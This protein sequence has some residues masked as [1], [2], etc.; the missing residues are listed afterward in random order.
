MTIM[1][2]VQIVI[3]WVVRPY[4]L[5]DWYRRFGGTCCF[6]FQ[7]WRLL[8]SF[9]FW[10]WMFL[11]HSDIRLQD[12]MVSVV[13]NYKVIN[14]LFFMHRHTRNILIEK[15]LREPVRIFLRLQV[16]I[17]PQAPKNFSFLFICFFSPSF[18]Q[19]YLHVCDSLFLLYSPPFTVKSWLISWIVV[20][21]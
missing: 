20:H 1:Y 5:T 15:Y 8:I 3:F 11:Q 10:R 12:Y 4:N 6:R 2:G 13:N 16:Q 17:R 7:G 14:Y 19:H 21:Y 9:Q 18:S